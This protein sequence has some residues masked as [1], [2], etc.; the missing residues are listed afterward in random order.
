MTLNHILEIANVNNVI[1]RAALAGYLTWFLITELAVGKEV[2]GSRIVDRDIRRYGIC[3]AAALLLWAIGA[4][5]ITLGVNLWRD[6]ADV[7]GVWFMVV[8]S[9]GTVVGNL[10]LIRILSVQRYGNWL[11][12]SVALINVA[13]T[14][15]ALSH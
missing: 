8:G 14:L 7:A 1:D 15:W 2:M 12:L 5:V 13:Y 3:L 6:H 11:W 4:L 10:M 9:V